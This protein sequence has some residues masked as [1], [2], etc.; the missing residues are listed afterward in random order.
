VIGSGKRLFGQGALP[1]GPKLTDS[2]TSSTGVIMATYEPAGE[3]RT[4][5][6]ELENP[7]EAE[8]SRRERLRDRV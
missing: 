6:F 2:K 3:L 5:T 4:G 8:I 1:S 7:S